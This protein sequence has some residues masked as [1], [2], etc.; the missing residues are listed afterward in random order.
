MHAP[1][2]TRLRLAVLAGA[3]ASLLLLVRA[4]PASGTGDGITFLLKRSRRVGIVLRIAD[5][6]LFF[7][8]RAVQPLTRYVF[9]NRER[10]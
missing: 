9:F 8:G 3:A 10:L 7:R 6:P 1:R 4:A 2:V 5:C